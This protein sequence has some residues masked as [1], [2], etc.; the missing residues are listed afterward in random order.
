MFYGREI[1]TDLVKFVSSS[2][3]LAKFQGL[4]FQNNRNNN[5]FLVTTMQT[6]FP[7]DKTTFD[8][9]ASIL[10][11][12]YDNWTN[13]HVYITILIFSISIIPLLLTVFILFVRMKQ[14]LNSTGSLAFSLFAALT[15]PQYIMI[16]SSISLQ[17]FV[18]CLVFTP[19]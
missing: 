14:Y 15:S 18:T 2:W 5:T 19:F 6:L 11:D 1:S 8:V 13:Q 16:I 7:A 9:Q 12:H 4:E 10:N 17:F 3:S